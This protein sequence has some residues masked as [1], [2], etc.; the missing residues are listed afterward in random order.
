MQ[1]KQI[2]IVDSKSGVGW[3]VGV[4]ASERQ[5]GFKGGHESRNQSR[6]LNT[7]PPLNFEAKIEQPD[8]CLASMKSKI[9]TI[10]TCAESILIDFKHR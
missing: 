7:P 2:E 3:G 9:P 6:V 1:Y 10:S 4:V 8:D 5:D